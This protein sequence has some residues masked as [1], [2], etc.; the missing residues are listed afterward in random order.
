M[1]NHKTLT[2]VQAAM[3]AAIYVVLVFIFNYWSFGAVQFRIAESLTILPYF[4]FAAVPGLFA[5]C[6]LANLLSGAVIGDVIFGSLATLA[7]ALGTYLAGKLKIKWL[8]P[9]PPIVSN[10]LII[11]F[12]LR[13][14]YGTEGTI[15]YMMVSI[16]LGEILSCAVCGSI[17]FV[18]IEKNRKTLFPS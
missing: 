12:V 10:T 15:P 7:G 18:F 3:I 11:P 5:G 6:L 16:G 8:A 13:Y 14:F 4:T 2:M 1:R 9:V 17:L